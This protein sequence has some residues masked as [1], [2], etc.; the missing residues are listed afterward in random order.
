[1]GFI[2]SRVILKTWKRYSQLLFLSLRTSGQYERKSCICCASCVFY[3]NTTQSFLI[4]IVQTIFNKFS[5]VCYSVSSKRS[6]IPLLLKIKIVDL[7]I[8]V[9]AFFALKDH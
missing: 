2:L 4:D 7:N 5:N 9:N 3:A 6:F 1:M 8:F